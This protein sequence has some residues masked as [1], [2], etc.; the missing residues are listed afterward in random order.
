MSARL[1]PD[2]TVYA[3]KVATAL[4]RKVAPVTDLDAAF[5]EAGP[6]PDSCDDKGRLRIRC[7]VLDVAPVRCWPD[8]MECS[9]CDGRGYTDRAAFTSSAYTSE[10]WRDKRT[11]ISYPARFHAAVHYPASRDKCLSCD[12]RG[13]FAKPDLDNIVTRILSAKS[14]GG[15]VSKRPKDDRAY[16]VWRM[17]RFHTGADVTMPFTASMDVR[18]D[19]YAPLL[20]R[21]AVELAKRLTGH[22]SAGSARWR[23]ALGYTDVDTTGMPEAAHEGGAVVLDGD[24]PRGERAE[25]CEQCPDGLEPDAEGCTEPACPVHGKGGTAWA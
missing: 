21:A 22:G 23:Q 18:G 8:T 2:E 12:G 1:S 24:K 9:I 16:Y 17:T 25:L 10:A 6:L 20:E 14:R 15:L 13:T 11:K 5:A 3:R 19:W 7:A 4:L